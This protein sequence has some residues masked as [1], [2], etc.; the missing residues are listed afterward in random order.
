MTG[1]RPID[2][3]AVAARTQCRRMIW[4]IATWVS[5]LLSITAVLFGFLTDESIQL[6]V[7]CALVLGVI[8]AAAVLLLAAVL[9]SLLSFLG[10]VYDFLRA[11]LAH[12]LVLCISL[13][14]AILVR[15]V[16]LHELHINRVLV[17]AAGQLVRSTMAGVIWTRHLLRKAAG[18]ARNGWTF[19]VRE[20]VLEA[21]WT[22]HLAGRLIEIIPF[23][24]AW[25]I[26]TSARLLLRF[27]DWKRLRVPACSYFSDLRAQNGAVTP[28]QVS[29][30]DTTFLS[31][32]REPCECSPGWCA[33]CGARLNSGKPVWAVLL[34]PGRAQPCKAMK[35]EEILPGPEFLQRERI[36]AAGFF[37][38]H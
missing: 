34:N 16:N 5:A 22:K 17:Q 30:I 26:R 24:A 35:V 11:A 33:S 18:G 32:V 28:E 27:I 20:V 21:R 10:T 38:R 3:S 4:E 19:V 13:L 6:H 1:S 31:P 2:C 14:R 23:M 9:A 12:G 8:P 7:T 37:H 29:A 15:S 36:A 25:P